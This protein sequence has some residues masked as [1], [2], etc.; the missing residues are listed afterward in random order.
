[1]NV[2]A[3]LFDTNEFFYPED[4]S[5]RSLSEFWGILE[6]YRIK[7]VEYELNWGT[8]MVDR[9]NKEIFSGDRVTIYYTD[10][11]ASGL[12]LKDRHAASII[13]QEGGH[14]DYMDGCF[15]VVNEQGLLWDL[16]N[17]MSA[18]GTLHIDITGNVYDGQTV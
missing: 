3:W 10:E 14:V 9:E 17:S 5:P 16:A 13:E 6:G 12:S 7:G 18:N 1:M 15:V 4:D 8:S 2:R 11:L